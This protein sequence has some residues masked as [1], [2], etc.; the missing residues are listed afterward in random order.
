MLFM[1]HHSI[2]IFSATA[3]LVPSVGRLSP[4]IDQNTGLTSLVCASCT[5]Q[6]KSLD[7]LENKKPTGKKQTFE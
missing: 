3:D 5:G 7:V 1:R 2:N 6:D 4:G